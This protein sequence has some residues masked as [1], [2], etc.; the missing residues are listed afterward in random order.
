MGVFVWLWTC[1]GKTRLDAE[2]LQPSLLIFTTG[3][4]LRRG[5]AGCRHQGRCLGVRAPNQC[6]PTEAQVGPEGTIKMVWG[7]GR[8]G[9]KNA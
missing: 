4:R 3:V 1:L 7:G 2:E 6:V 5:D 8:E 9:V